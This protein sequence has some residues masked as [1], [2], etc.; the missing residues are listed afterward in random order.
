MYN[1][2]VVF[3]DEHTTV[4][5]LLQPFSLN[6]KVENKEVLFSRDRLIYEEREKIRNIISDY[7]DKL[8]ISCISKSQ[9]AKLN[10]SKNRLEKFLDNASDE[11]IYNYAI[12]VYDKNLIS[13]E[14]HIYN[15]YNPYAKWASY[16]KDSES[17]KFFVIENPEK[18]GELIRTNSAKV[19]DIKW[20]EVKYGIVP[21]ESSIMPDGTW[22]DENIG[23]CIKVHKDKEQKVTLERKHI[24]EAVIKNDLEWVANIVEYYI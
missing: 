16:N 6:Q 4:E 9:K 21:S 7:N 1:L 3:T 20:D 2:V 11:E 24:G 19:K 22:Y 18:E 12:R 8:R 13:P 10:N 5:E 23:T 17:T 14:G 15:P